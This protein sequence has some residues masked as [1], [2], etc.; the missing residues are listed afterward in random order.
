MLQDAQDSLVMSL[1]SLRNTLPFGL[2]ENRLKRVTLAAETLSVGVEMES[3]VMSLF[4]M[5][6]NF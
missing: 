4:M 3:P 1:E 6:A 2:E 5:E